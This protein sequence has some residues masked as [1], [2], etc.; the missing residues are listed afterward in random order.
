MSTGRK[1][2]EEEKRKVH[3]Y[4]LPRAKEAYPGATVR[5]VVEDYLDNEGRANWR[6]IAHSTQVIP[7]NSGCDS[8]AKQKE[9]ASVLAA[10]SYDA[11]SVAGVV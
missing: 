3:D 7:N 4:A 9:A 5:V 2:T 1:L 8:A 10:V 11:Q 6:V